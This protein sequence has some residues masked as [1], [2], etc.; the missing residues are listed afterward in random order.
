MERIEKQF[1]EKLAQHEVPP[2]ADFW[3]QISGRLDREDVQAAMKQPSVKNVLFTPKQLLRVAAAV[4]FLLGVGSVTYFQ[5]TETGKPNIAATEKMQGTT[6]SDAVKVEQASVAQP[7][8]ITVT[9]EKEAK[10]KKTVFS[11]E[12]EKETVA[13]NR[14]EEKRVIEDVVEELPVAEQTTKE[15]QNASANTTTEISSNSIPVYSLKLLD[16]NLPAND[17]ITVIER[18]K[19]EKEKKQDDDD[20]KVIIIEK[21]ISKQPEIKYQLPLRF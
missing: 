10:V 17:E 11:P 6:D 9:K 5:T 13:N 2:P 14:S 18:N 21:S 15:I 12:A 3:H 20:A 7:I 16:K 1:G 8:A 4:V 19:K